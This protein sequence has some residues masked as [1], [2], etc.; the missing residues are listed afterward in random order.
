MAFELPKKLE[1][2][3][4]LA[5]ALREMSPDQFINESLSLCSKLSPAIW[6]TITEIAHKNRVNE[7]LAVQ[8]IIIRYLAWQI[9]WEEI[10]PKKDCPTPE[11]SQV[12]GGVATGDVIGWRELADQVSNYEFDA[13]AIHTPIT[14]P[15]DI[16]LNYF[17]NG[18]VNPWG[19]VEAKA[20][21]LIA[22]CLNKPVAHAP[23]ESTSSEDDELYFILQQEKIDPRMSAES[24]SVGSSFLISMRFLSRFSFSINT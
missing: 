7:S 16:A 19:G 6:P 4:E 22:D 9:A 15:R 17:R 24:V 18:G 12:K 3:V 10:F 8:N 5:A 13:L 20:S 23:I 11:F 14:V 21:K 1:Q 2:Q